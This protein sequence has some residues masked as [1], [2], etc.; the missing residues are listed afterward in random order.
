MDFGAQNEKRKKIMNFTFWHH[1]AGKLRHQSDDIPFLDPCAVR[2][3]RISPGRTTQVVIF[4]PI[5]KWFLIVCNQ[6]KKNRASISTF[7]SIIRFFGK[8]YSKNHSISIPF[9]NFVSTVCLAFL[10][11]SALGSYASSCQ[12]DA[13][14][15][16]INIR[17]KIFLPHIRKK[18]GD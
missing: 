8:P 3:I 9:S 16:E 18:Y 17:R 14:K 2:L 7:L 4:V 1:G 12:I 11:G 6:K 15:N 13:T 10:F 5:S